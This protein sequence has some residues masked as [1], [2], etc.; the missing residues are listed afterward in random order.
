MPLYFQVLTPSSSSVLCRSVSGVTSTASFFVAPQ[1]RR[2]CAST[3]APVGVSVVLAMRMQCCLRYL[4]DTHRSLRA[5]PVRQYNQFPSGSSFSVHTVQYTSSSTAMM[6]CVLVNSRRRRQDW[7][8]KVKV[9]CHEAMYV[10]K[11][12]T[13]RRYSALHLHFTLGHS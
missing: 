9:T 6:P 12:L 13:A 11:V 7:Y 8:S 5:V 10:G 3:A 2:E 1:S 4:E